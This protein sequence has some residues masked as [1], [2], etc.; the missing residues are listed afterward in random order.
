VRVP[1]TA[2]GRKLLDLPRVELMSL[3]DPLLQVRG[4]LDAVIFHGLVGP[5]DGR[6]SAEGAPT[7]CSP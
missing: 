3:E 6:T 7:R 1:T 4:Q 2:N 5:A